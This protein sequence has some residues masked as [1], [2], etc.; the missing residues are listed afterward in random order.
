MGFT[1]RGKVEGLAGVMATLDAL[2]ARLRGKTLR[3]A[4]R[5]AGQIIVKAAKANARAA[6]ET[7]QLR[8]SIGVKVRLY[9]TTG[10]LLVVVGPR[11]GFKAD[12]V[13]ERNKWFRTTMKVNP[14]RYAHLVELGT[15]RS[16]ARPFLAP[17]LFETAAAVRAAVA[18]VVREALK[19][20]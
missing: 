1:I 2:D 12:R 4:G 5:A 7:G 13:R 15:G 3:K 18:E 6:D 20:R 11:T 14:V 19:G 16:R 9:R 8:K 17:A 10:N